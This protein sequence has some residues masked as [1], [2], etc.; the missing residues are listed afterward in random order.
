MYRTRKTSDL[1]SYGDFQLYPDTQ[2]Q[3]V[4]C[5]G[6]I[7]RIRSVLFKEENCFSELAVYM[8]RLKRLRLCETW[9]SLVALEETRQERRQFAEWKDNDQRG[10]RTLNYADQLIRF[11]RID[12]ADALLVEVESR[13][14]GYKWRGTEKRLRLHLQYPYDWTLEKEWLSASALSI[15]VDEIVVLRLVGAAIQRKRVV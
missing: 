2:W 1:R 4:S 10:D 14:D 12:E 3:H 6:D 7:K 13:F 8:K 11:G 5:Y 15:P 9:L